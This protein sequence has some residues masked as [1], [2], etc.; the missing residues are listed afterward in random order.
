MSRLHWVIAI[1]GITALAA[2]KSK[3]I[4]S[5]DPRLVLTPSVD[6]AA[7]ESKPWGSGSINLNDAVL[8][9]DLGQKASES[10]QSGQAN[11]PYCVTITSDDVV[12]GE[13][14]CQD[15]GETFPILT[16]HVRLLCSSDPTM[17]IDPREAPPACTSAQV[18]HLTFNFD[19]GFSVGAR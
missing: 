15:N 14:R 9:V 6:P 5:G 19:V 13:A 4:R 10:P 7:A 1:L 18:T 16:K 8:Q 11:M 3:S 17:R 12:L 2:C